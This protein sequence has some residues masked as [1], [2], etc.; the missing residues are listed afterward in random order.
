MYNRYIKTG[1]LINNSEEYSDLFI[2]KN[3]TSV[4]QYSTYNFS[5]ISEN[6]KN[7]LDIVYHSFSAQDKLYNIS[8]K[9]YGSPEY[10]WLICYT[11]NIPNELS[12]KEGDLLKIYL[13]LNRIL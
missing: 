13:P 8:E 3:V 1:I 9:Y 6:I 10:S 5:K 12:I 11:N 7:N 4:K 2:Q